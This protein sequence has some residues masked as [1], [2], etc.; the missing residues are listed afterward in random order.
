[1]F[2]S[3]NLLH[4]DLRGCG[5]IRSGWHYKEL[6]AELAW[7]S[8][9]VTVARI[10]HIFRRP[11]P[12]CLLRST[13]T[14]LDATESHT[15]V[16]Y[17]CNLEDKAKNS[18]VAPELQGAACRQS[19]RQLHAFV[20]ASYHQL[21]SLPGTQAIGS[22][23]GSWI[24]QVQIRQDTILELDSASKTSRCKLEDRLGLQGRQDMA[25]RDTKKVVIRRRDRP[26]PAG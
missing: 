10:F 17:R 11:P 18:K 21:I 1:M 26:G 20:G 2:D 12:D 23:G 5:F 3:A 25:G 22:G 9:T 14:Q 7:H 19:D 6:S 13:T 15:L 4:Q 8:Q 16:L 24:N